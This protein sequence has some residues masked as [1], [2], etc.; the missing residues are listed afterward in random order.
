MT[1]TTGAF[2]K[3]LQQGQMPGE[4]YVADSRFPVLQT[5]LSMPEVQAVIPPGKEILFGSDSALF[6]N[7]VFSTIYVAR[8]EADHNR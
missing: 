6:A 8:L 5:Y 2:S 4:Y 7:K 1:P 3:L